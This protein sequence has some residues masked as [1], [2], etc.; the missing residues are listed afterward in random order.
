MPLFYSDVLEHLA[1]PTGTLPR[2]V[3]ATKV[4]SKLMNANNFCPVIKCHL[5]GTFHLRNSFRFIAHL[6]GL[7]NNGDLSCGHSE[8]F[9]RL[10][11]GVTRGTLVRVAV[12]VFKHTFSASLSP[13]LWRHLVGGYNPGSTCVFCI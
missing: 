9:E 11:G 2:L 8:V 13:S 5:Q 12:A 10:P 6:S 1:D 7:R 3:E 4:G